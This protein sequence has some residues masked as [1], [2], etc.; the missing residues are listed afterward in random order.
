MLSGQGSIFVSIY[1]RRQLFFPGFLFEPVVGCPFS[2]ILQIIPI[3]CKPVKEPIGPVSLQTRKGLHIQRKLF[4]QDSE[5]LLEGSIDL[6][7]LLGCFPTYLLKD[8]W[9]VGFA[10]GIELAEKA[11]EA[12]EFFQGASQIDGCLLLRIAMVLKLGYLKTFQACFG[13]R[14][15]LLFLFQ[16]VEQRQGFFFRHFL[17]FSLRR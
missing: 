1:H 2:Q 9:R 8:R 7:K 5:V 3:G 15:Q 6:K 4:F 10:L 11:P 13:F 17:S 14:F 12:F 16:S